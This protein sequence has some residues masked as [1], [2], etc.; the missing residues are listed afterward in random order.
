MKTKRYTD[1]EIKIKLSNLKDDMI[2]YVES[3]K[4]S[5]KNI[6][7]L[8]SKYNKDIHNN[9]TTMKQYSIGK[10]TSRSVEQNRGQNSHKYHQCIIDKKAL[11]RAGHS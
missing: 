1:Y 6:L 10:W 5:T 7:E 8:I 2:F 3:S 11:N 4:E 9:K